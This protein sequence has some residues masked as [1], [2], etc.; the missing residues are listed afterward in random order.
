MNYSEIRAELER[1]AET[2]ATAESILKLSYAW[3]GIR[4]HTH[5]PYR[6]IIDDR[7]NAFGFSRLTVCADDNDCASALD[8]WE[9]REIVIPPDE[10][11]QLA[12][13]VTGWDEE[14]YSN[15]QSFIAVMPRMEWLKWLDVYEVADLDEETVALLTE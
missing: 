4:N 10:I 6:P 14:A 3:A 2:G 7:L 1:L 15:D 11:G 12:L 5:Q 13:D 8:I 9:R